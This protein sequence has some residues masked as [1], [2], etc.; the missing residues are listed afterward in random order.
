MDQAQQERPLGRE[1]DALDK[2]VSIMGE[3]LDSHAVMVDPVRLRHPTVGE[4]EKDVPEPERSEY[5]GRL[6][7][8]ARRV[9]S[10]RTELVA[11]TGELRI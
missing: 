9:A 7:G 3:A 11:L 5:E 2:E 1:I 6:V 4:A 8:I 10:I